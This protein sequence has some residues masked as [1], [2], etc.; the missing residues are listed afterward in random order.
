MEALDIDMRISAARWL[1]EKVEILFL[2]RMFLWPG[3]REEVGAYGW[4]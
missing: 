3:S 4:E 1:G 2:K